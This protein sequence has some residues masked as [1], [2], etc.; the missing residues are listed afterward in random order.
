MEPPGVS[1]GTFYLYF[2]TKDDVISAL[3]DDRSQS[4]ALIDAI[5]RAEADPVVGLTVLFDLH[6][7]TLADVKRS[8]E[9]RV[10]ILGW[11]EALRK[12]PIRRRLLANM[13]RVQQEIAHLIERGQ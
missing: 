2:E 4:D 8:D 12:E 7:R 6:G 5:A 13:S 1:Q 10:V 3:P 11:A 9:R